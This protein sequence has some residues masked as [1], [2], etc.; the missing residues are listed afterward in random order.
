MYDLPLPIQS[1]WRRIKWIVAWW[2]RHILKILFFLPIR[3]KRVILSAHGGL[4]YFCNPKY[5]SEYLIRYGGKD[6]EIIWGFIHPEKYSEIP[7]IK[8]VKVNS[9]AWF[10]Y[11]MTASVIVLN[12]QCPQLQLKRKGQVLINTWHGGGA[13]KR[14]GPDANKLNMAR[15]EWRSASYESLYRRLICFFP[16]PRLLPSMPSG[17]TTATTG[18]NCPAVCRAMICFLIQRSGRK[19]SGRLEASWE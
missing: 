17:R 8:A 19:S 10:Y 13:Y 12:V 5:I 1:F 16:V 14:V 15:I 2:V 9:P 6:L 11:A 7:G 3:K 18:R 4:R